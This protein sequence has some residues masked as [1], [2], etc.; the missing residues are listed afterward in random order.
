ME[1]IANYLVS[2]K[3]YESASTIVYRATRNVDNKNVILKVL[4]QDL[5]TAVET[6]RY[7][8]EHSIIKDLDNKGIIKSFGI[9]KHKN[10][11]IIV[12]EDFAGVSLKEFL[13]NKPL[14]LEDFL[15]LAIQ[16]SGSLSYIHSCHI[17]HKDIN[18]ANIV[19]NPET[20][21]AKIIDFGIASRLAK[22]KTSLGSPEHL[23]G[24]LAYIAPEQTGRINRNVDYRADLYSLGCTFYEMLTGH[25][26]FKSAQTMELVHSQIAKKPRTLSS[27]NSDVPNVISQLVLKLLSKNAEDRYQSANFLKDELVLCLQHLQEFGSLDN[28]TLTIATSD[29]SGV[30]SIPQKLYGRSDETAKLL[31]TFERASQGPAEMVIIGGYSGAGKTV[32]VNE[33]HLPMTKHRGYFTSGKFDQFQKNIP[34]YAITQAL[35]YFCRSLLTE[36]Q[37]QLSDK[38]KKIMAA[39]GEYGQVLLNIIPEL[40]LIIGPQP[41]IAQVGAA[42]EHSRFNEVFLN[43]FNALCVKEHPLILFIDDL[44]WADSASLE[45]LHTLMTKDGVQYLLVIGAFRDNEVDDNHP[46]MQMVN[47]LS[48]LATKVTQITLNNLSPVDVSRMIEDSLLCDSDYCKSLTRLVH[49]KTLGNAFFTQ[50][51]LHTLADKKLLTFDFTAKQWHWDIKQ[52]A[53]EKITDNVV[54]LM[55]AKISTLE[56]EKSELLQF[57]ACIGNQ[58]DLNTLMI[59]SEHDSAKYVLDNLWDAMQGGLIIPLNEHYKLIE[60]TSV[61]PEQVLFKFLHDRIQQAA[62]SLII[63][64]NR[65]K[66]HL[67]AGRLL[68]E[69]YNVSDLLDEKLFEIINQYNKGSHLVEDQSEKLI[70]A[71]L[72]LQAGQKAVNSAAYLA[73]EEYF[74]AA[75]NDLPDDAMDTHYALAFAI[76]LN[77]AKNYYTLNKFDMSRE[78]YP[79]LLAAAQSKMDKISVYAIQMDDLHLQG[80][81]EKA[82]A[83][84]IQAL[85]LLGIDV[86]K[87]DKQKLINKELSKVPLYLAGRDIG[88]LANAQEMEVGEH[89]AALKI[90]IGMWMSSYLLSNNAMVEWASVKMCNLCLEHGNS[91]LASFAYVQY[92]YVCINRLEAFD[93]GYRFGEVALTIADHYP[94]LDLRGKVYF[95]FGL[96]ISHWKKHVNDS[97]EAFRKGYRYSVEAG[98]WTYASYG[99]A[100]I[101]S[102]LLTDGHSCQDVYKEAKMYLAFLKDKS[103]EALKSFFIPGGFCAILNLIEKTEDPST[104]DCD[105]LNE[106]QF[107]AHYNEQS[108]VLAFFYAVKIRSLYLFGQYQDALG[109]IS[110]TNIVVT[111]VPGQIKVAEVYFYNC[112]TLI[113]ADEFV[114]NKQQRTDLWGAFDH[115]LAKIKLWAEQCPANFEHK[116]LLIEAERSRLENNPLGTTFGLYQQALG[117]AKKYHYLN[118][119]ALCHELM[120]KFW[121]QNDHQ[122]Y[123]DAHITDAIFAYEEW[124]ATAKVKNMYDQYPH[125]RVKAHGAVTTE[126]VS[127][128]SSSSLD[129]E[130]VIKASNILSSEIILEQLLEKMLQIVLE[131][132]GATRVVLILK[133]GDEWFIE[134]QTLA[135]DTKMSVLQSIPLDEFDKVPVSL[136]RY[137]IRTQKNGVYNNGDFK[138]DKYIQLHQPKSILVDLLLNQGELIGVLYVENNLTAGVFDHERLNV[139]SLLSSQI[140][141]SIK[142][143]MF[144]KNL[145]TQVEKRTDELQTLLV[146]LTETQKQLVESEKMASLG[147]LVAGISHELNTPLGIS[148]TLASHLQEEVV[149]LARAIEDKSIKRSQLDSF[150]VDAQKNCDILLSN[151]VRAAE[152]IASFKKIAVDQSYDVIYSFVPSHYIDEVLRSLDH[153]FKKTNIAIATCVPENE[154]Q[155]SSY[156]GAVIQIITNLMMNSYIHAFDDGKKAGQIKLTIEQTK[157]NTT[158]IYDDNGVGMSEHA[159]KSIFEPFFTTRRGQGGSGLGMSIVYNLAVHKLLG[160]IDCQ[161]KTGKGTTFTLVMPNHLENESPVNSTMNCALVS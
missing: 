19:I 17:I 138:Q 67:Q 54:D 41:A 83:V 131:N 61:K 69:S 134:G 76:H 158:L 140:A 28:L 11:F 149:K 65:T 132:S 147:K 3:I 4:K 96:A 128:I 105:H 111:G 36:T 6:N 120:A 29:F 32:L 144:Y 153:K 60:V 66:A 16:L 45:L 137:V 90:L 159:A 73:A 71:K 119:V 62:Y 127:E 89:K 100:C 109:L 108:I 116:H 59:I 117:S 70:I 7:Q 68:F 118:I 58:F 27:I 22:E 55:A 126:S 143:S 1:V 114:D 37:V 5:P 52:I 35:N 92:G 72:N 15:T 125:H 155:V 87:G 18:P 104:F 142:N 148:V 64:K 93:M 112:L 78:L 95:M 39:I 81:Y 2:E 152:L 56:V 122:H 8:Y 146:N 50:Q 161:S 129:L 21:E 79:R 74:L 20:R 123:A 136:I 75:Q 48:T 107:L 33:T 43:F 23:E 9:E 97:I 103:S 84:Q 91:E 40:E 99:A 57:A 102:N 133:N 30:F 94:S 42:E 85:T 46:F 139:I 12:L 98:D 13:L 113:A 31:A 156:P 25:I 53:T 151:N 145:E 80:D 47:S 44:Q 38:R 135:E 130:S 86:P 14:P 160:T 124:G 101:V 106:S 115:Y 51:F 10:T 24:T 150:L 34:Y 49:K 141:I 154:K 88:D 26:P 121:I 110:Q 157:Q 82:L 77:A 63:E